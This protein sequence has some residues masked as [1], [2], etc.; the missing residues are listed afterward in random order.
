MACSG[1]STSQNRTKR[2]SCH[3]VV[4]ARATQDRPSPAEAA[5]VMA[6]SPGSGKPVPGACTLVRRW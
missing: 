5:A 3:A 4:R 1:E 2:P 6:S